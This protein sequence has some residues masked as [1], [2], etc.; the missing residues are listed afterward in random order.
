M[1]PPVAPGGWMELL[2]REK[3][4]AGGRTNMSFEDKA[5]FYLTAIEN[6]G[7]PLSLADA[8]GKWAAAH[9]FRTR[10]K[11]KSRYDYL[12]SDRKRCLK[13]LPY[14]LDSVYDRARSATIDAIIKFK[15]TF[16]RPPRCLRNNNEETMLFYRYKDILYLARKGQLSKYHHNKMTEQGLLPPSTRDKNNFKIRAIELFVKRHRRWPT[17][18]GGKKGEHMLH[19]FIRN[20]LYTCRYHNPDSDNFKALRDLPGCPFKDYNTVQK[21]GNSK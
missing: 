12:T 8:T 20:V 4:W 13:E 10:Y 21:K 1:K 6:L 18:N 14:F 9:R 3:G 7:R 17:R 5:A 15:H 11:S 2:D 19:Q 16:D